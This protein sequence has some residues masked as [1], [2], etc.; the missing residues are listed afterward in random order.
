[1][2]I[3]ALT[4]TTVLDDKTDF[5]LVIMS[6]AVGK[7]YPHCKLH[8]AMNKVACVRRVEAPPGKLME[9]MPSLYL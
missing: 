5:S 4:D 7:L 8:V 1:M 9:K 2:K 6:E 3:Q